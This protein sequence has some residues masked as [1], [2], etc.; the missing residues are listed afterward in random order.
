M[1]ERKAM[2]AW[3][4]PSAKEESEAKPNEKASLTSA[5]SGVDLR[6]SDKPSAKEVLTFIECPPKQNGVNKCCSDAI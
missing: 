3:A 4:L 1:S 2:L 5:P 6:F